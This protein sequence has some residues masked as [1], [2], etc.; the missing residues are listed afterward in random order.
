MSSLIA[1]HAPLNIVK[2]GWIGFPPFF[3][4]LEKAA[5]RQELLFRVIRKN[6]STRFFVLSRVWKV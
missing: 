3:E 5:T 6:Q 2:N 4:L 1:I